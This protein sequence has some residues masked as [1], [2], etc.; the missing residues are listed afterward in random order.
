MFGRVA[1]MKTFG[2]IPEKSPMVESYIYWAG[3]LLKKESVSGVFLT[4][5]YTFA[6]QL[7]ST[8]AYLEPSPVSTMKLFLW[9]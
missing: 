8:E 1:L 2:K 6:E 7:Y 5:L 3:N 4:I 9:N